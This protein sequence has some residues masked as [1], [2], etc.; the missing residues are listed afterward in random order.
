MTMQVDA[1]KVWVVY[2][3]SHFALVSADSQEHARRLEGKILGHYLT[4]DEAN[5]ALNTMK[6]IGRLGYQLGRKA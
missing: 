1:D 2:T 3:D 4:S 6:T 5:E